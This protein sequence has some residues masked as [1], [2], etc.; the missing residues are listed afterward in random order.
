MSWDPASAAGPVLMSLPFLT[1]VSHSCGCMLTKDI[2][3]LNM[4]HEIPSR[5]IPAGGG[6]GVG[7]GVGG[8]G[9]EGVGGEKMC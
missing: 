7:S 8:G 3:V 9:V 2:N 6:G 4:M 5:V 1:V